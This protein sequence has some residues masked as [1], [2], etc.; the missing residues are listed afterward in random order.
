MRALHLC[1]SG[2]HPQ[3]SHNPRPAAQSPDEASRLKAFHD[4]FGGL[5]DEINYVD[6]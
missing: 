5:D 2:N 6:F 4:C 3:P 1:F